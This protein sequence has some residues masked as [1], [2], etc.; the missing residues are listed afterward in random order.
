MRPFVFDF[1]VPFVY[2]VSGTLG[3]P[4]RATIRQPFHGAKCITKLGSV[5][6]AK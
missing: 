5:F 2:A 3:S 1:G 4:I 6:A